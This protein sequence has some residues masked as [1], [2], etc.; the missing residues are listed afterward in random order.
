MEKK[1]FSSFADFFISGIN[2][3]PDLQKHFLVL[4]LFAVHN[5]S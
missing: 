1:S 5:Q 3:K 2:T 4:R